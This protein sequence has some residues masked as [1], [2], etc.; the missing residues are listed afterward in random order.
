[1]RP[2]RKEKTAK[3]LIEEFYATEAKGK[4]S[5]RAHRGVLY[6]RSQREGSEPESVEKESPR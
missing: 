3:G 4:N 1:M 5:K 6:D 2:K